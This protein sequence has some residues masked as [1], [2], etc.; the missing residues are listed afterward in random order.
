MNF[1]SIPTVEQLVELNL[2]V[3]DTIKYCQDEL[4]VSNPPRPTKPRLAD[5]HTSVDVLTYANALVEYETTN[6]LYEAACKEV[7]LHN[8]TVGQLID[9]Y[10]INESG[11]NS[12][13]KQYRQKVFSYASRD[14]D[15]RYD[16]FCHLENLI[17]I[18]K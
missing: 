8:N 11:L 9:E 1:P 17:D 10:I 4:Q 7:R 18:F 15:N 5:K 13:P 12:I 14:A 6:S 3:Y 16:V 2:D